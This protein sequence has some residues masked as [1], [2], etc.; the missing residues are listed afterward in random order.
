MCKN[1]HFLQFTFI[2][3]LFLGVIFD[4]IEGEDVVILVDARHW[5]L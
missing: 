4:I 1:V 2:V 3:N 5:L